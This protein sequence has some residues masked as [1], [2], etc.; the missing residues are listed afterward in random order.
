MGMPCSGL[1][2]T[3]GCLRRP[4]PA[5]S[6]TPS[7]PQLAIRHVGTVSEAPRGFRERITGG[8]V[9]PARPSVSGTRR[10]LG[11]ES[12]LTPRGGLLKPHPA[13]SLSHLHPGSWTHAPQ[14]CFGFRFCIFAKQPLTGTWTEKQLKG[15]TPFQ[16]LLFPSW[17]FFP[18]FS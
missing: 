17:S 12:G 3:T 14:G 8:S 2:S 15:S 18:P 6:R 9:R 10:E 1:F 7:R 4:G 13:L 11:R 16:V 5:D